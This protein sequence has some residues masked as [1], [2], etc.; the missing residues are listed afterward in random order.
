MFIGK[1]IFSKI[2]NLERKKEIFM[3]FRNHLEDIFHVNN[4]PNNKNS[5]K[6]MTFKN[7]YY[8]KLF[9][10]VLFFNSKITGNPTVQ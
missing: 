10:V 3:L 7:I 6:K 9:I 4:L 5:L 8:T 1:I 2:L